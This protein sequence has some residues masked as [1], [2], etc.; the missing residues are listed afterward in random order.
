LTIVGQ[1]ESN[2]FLKISNN[3]STFGYE[4]IAKN[5]LGFCRYL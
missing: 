3:A 1:L 4:L 5:K 2:E